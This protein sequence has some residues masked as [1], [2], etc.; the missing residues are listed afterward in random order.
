[1][2][3]PRISDKDLGHF[4]LQY[5]GFKVLG[6]ILWPDQVGGHSAQWQTLSQS[7][8]VSTLGKQRIG[9]LFLGC[10]VYQLW[11]DICD[12]NLVNSSKALSLWSIYKSA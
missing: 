12:S 8:I 4:P 5:R 7:C 2:H 9:K 1:M 10:C 3:I 11:L 6:V